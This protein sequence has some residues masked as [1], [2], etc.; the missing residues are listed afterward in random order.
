MTLRFYR[1]PRMVVL[2]EDD[3]ALDAARANPSTQ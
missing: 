2:R 1:R 3:T